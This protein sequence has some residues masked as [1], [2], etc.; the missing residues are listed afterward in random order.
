[1]LFGLWVLVV[2]D[3]LFVVCGLFVW[4]EGVRIG[5][6]LE[7]RFGWMGFFFGVVRFYIVNLYGLLSVFVR[8]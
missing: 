7:V 1:M 6:I 2:E 5:R 3:E 8:L 4:G